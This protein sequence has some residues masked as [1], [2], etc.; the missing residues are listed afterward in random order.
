M[1]KG[2]IYDMKWKRKIIS[3][4]LCMALALG[5]GQAAF[6]AMTDEEAD[7]ANAG[8]AGTIGV[9]G[10]DYASGEVIVVFEEGTTNSKVGE[11]LSDNDAS[12]EKK[13]RVDG[14][15]V[16]LASVDE[17]TSVEEVID[18]IEEENKV[19]YVQPNYKYSLTATDPYY[20]PAKKGTLYYQKQFDM[21]K[22]KEAWSE[23]G[24]V[25]K[26]TIVCVLDTGV[27]MSHEDLTDNL[28]LIDGKKQ[29]RQYSGSI[30]RLAASDSGWHGTHVAGIIGAVY[31][32]GKG[33]A[34]IAAGEAGAPLVKVLPVGASGDGE[35]LYT[36]DI[37]LGMKYAASKGARVINMSFGALGRDRVEGEA[38]KELY[39]NKGITFVAAA[40][41]ER[42]D[43]YSDP[44]DM[45]EV[46]SVCNYDVRA[47]ATLSWEDTDSNYGSA[48][49]ISAPGQGI[50]SS[51]PVNKYSR[52]SG[53]SMATP[54]VS[55]ICAMVLDA[56][57]N[58]TPAQVRN[59]ICATAKKN[60][61]IEDNEMGYGTVD[62]EAAVKAAKAASA[63]VPVE[64]VEIKTH[65]VTLDVDNATMRDKG[66]GM[67]TLVFPA[68]SLADVT[69]SSSRESV[70]TVD[71]YGIVT[72][73]SPGTCTITASAGDAPPDTCVVT[74]KGGIDPTGISFSNYPK[75]L[76]VGELYELNKKVKIVPST[77]TNDEV[78]WS[79]SDPK[80]ALVEEGIIQTKKAGKCTI[81][82][83]TYNGH[84]ASF[85]LTVTAVPTAVKFTRSVYWMR[86][87]TTFDFNAQLVDS[88]GRTG[89]SNGDMNWSISPK[90]CGSINSATG[91]F[92]P[93][94]AALT[95]GYV[96]VYAVSQAD[97]GSGDALWKAKKVTI[98]KR[99]Y[100]GKSSYRLKKGTVK[101]RR[102]TIR[103]KKIPG[104]DRYIIQR[105]VG[106]KGKFKTVKKV[107]A[108]VVLKNSGY[109]S[110]TNKKLA[111]NRVYRYRVRAQFKENGSRK[112]FG[113]SNTIKIKTKK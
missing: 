2:K 112:S 47:G 111:K 45:K 26:P 77:A 39:Y 33:G 23:V 96:Y 59:I 107:K 110:Y 43:E 74:V 75:K 10:E 55:G 97:D 80:V 67:E 79:S 17:G 36:M 8:P 113:W 69:W 90:S 22:A 11:I 72:P 63:D 76:S 104:A 58:L 60:S 91:R 13:T 78:Y 41:N 29:Y 19:A 44:S 6:A 94:K 3:L 87:G 73:K 70:A 66:Y 24:S 50:W 61:V 86:W 5:T 14:S 38:I 82:A 85:V 105:A 35:S 54:I 100:K 1:R 65:S 92:T 64:R 15:T 93:N 48:K 42:T 89:I 28:V 62:A 53:T 83:S 56:N 106:K 108:K 57:P 7:G 40:G 101:K 34:G 51:I 102:A 52:E 21:T 9:E 4:M 98:I 68:E 95:N 18:S 30:A 25:S 16:A 103:W 88:T 20:D 99:N 49:D 12:L 37:V 46:I 27:D 32:N 84:R 81:T 31:G 71:K 109:I